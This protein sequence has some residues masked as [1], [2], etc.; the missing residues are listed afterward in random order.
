MKFLTLLLS[1][2]ASQLVFSQISDVQL[3]KEARKKLKKLTVEEKIAQTCQLTLDA[4]LKVD[5]KGRVLEPLQIDETKLKEVIKTNGVGSI[6]NVSSHT[7]DLKTWA[8]ITTKVHQ[9]YQIGETKTPV[10]YGVDAIHG[11]NYVIGGTL[12]PQEIGLAATWNPALAEEMGKIT[13]YETRA[14]GVPWN[15]SPVLD[16]GRQPLWSRYFE[17]LGEDPYLVS[18]MGEGLVK[19]YQGKSL[20]DPYTVLS[21]MKHFVGYSYPNSGRDRT[22]AW[23]PKRQMEE[24]FLPPF[25]SAVEAGSLSVMI[26]SGDVNGIP[27]HIN[28]HLITEVLKNRWGFKGFAVSDWEDFRMLH[29]VHKV[30]KDQKEAIILAFNAGVDMSMVPYYTTYSEYLKLFKEAVEEG[31]ISKKRLDDAVARILFVKLKLGLYKKQVYNQEMYSK[32]GSQEFKI[33]AKQAA[34]ESITLLKNEKNLLPLSK[35]ERIL[36]VGEAADNLIFQNGA[37]THTWQGV[38]TAYNTAG[39]FTIRQAFEKQ[40][41]ATNLKFSK[42]YDLSLVDG[43]ETCNLIDV[44]WLKI[45]AA[46]ADKIVVCLGEMPATEKPGDVRSLNLPAAYVELM[47]ELASTGKP[48]VLVTLFGKP[49]IVREVEP[50]A[51]AIYNAYLPGDYGSEALVDL[52]FGKENPSGKLPFTYPK[53]DGVIEHYDYTSAEAKSGKNELNQAHDPQWPFGFGMS[54]TNF[55]YTNLK[56]SKNAIQGEDD[57]ITGEITVTNTGKSKGKETVQWYV[58][59]EFASIAPANKRI[60]G[61]EKIEL[62]PG[63]SK[64]VSFK[65]LPLTLEFVGQENKWITEKGS[66]TISVGG[67][68]ASF[69][70]K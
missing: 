53:Y 59:D 2:F 52:V 34:L 29:S 31:R 55:S 39:A 44:N 70:L 15:F 23:I 66:F 5:E 60:K 54:Y 20:D 57:F 47:K 19:G 69:E 51:T 63:E 12:F 61:F 24:L 28:H 36:L 27:G 11:A 10:L 6:L 48:I 21:C 16:L 37:W 9:F 22:P 26:N 35:N 4:V 1:V 64:T 7:L 50:F 43:W 32:F 41:G 25:K 14:S 3:Q 40:I 33:A 67:Q 30:A 45:E 65:I 68:K 38:D 46:M 17:T 62:N 49:R 13:A 56:L 18:K 8:S 42:G 58:T